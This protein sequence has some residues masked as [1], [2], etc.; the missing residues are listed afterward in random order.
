ME[1]VEPASGLPYVLNDE[2]AWEVSVEPLLILKR[3]VH[4]RKRHGAGFEPA[5]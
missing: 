4:L 1:C 5:I 3:V 2:V